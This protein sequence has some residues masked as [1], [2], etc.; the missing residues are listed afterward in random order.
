[1]ALRKIL[2][3]PHP[4]LRQQAEAV[5]KF[6]AELERLLTDMAETMYEAP[7]IGLAANQ[8]GIPLQVVVIDIGPKDE[9]KVL[10]L[11]NPQIVPLGEECETNEEGC[12]SVVDLC[13]KVKRFRKIGVTALDRHGEPLDFVAEEMFARVVQHEVD[14][15]RGTLF[16]DHLSSLK[17]ALYK[18]KRKKQLQQEEEAA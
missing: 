8:I 12:L 15:L 1:M 9:K 11:I 13:A 10:E 4:I 18:K 16:L 7:G 5:T 14:H 3:Y 6:D 2:I 17:R